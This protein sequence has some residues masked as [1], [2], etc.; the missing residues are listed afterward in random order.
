MG[1]RNE[2]RQGVD[3]NDKCHGWRY[4][5]GMTNRK[6]SLHLTSLI[7]SKDFGYSI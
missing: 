7:S 4:G 1:M 6:S 2:K 3:G 5:I